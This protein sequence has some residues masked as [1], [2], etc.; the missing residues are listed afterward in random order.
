[1]SLVRHSLGLL[2][3][4]FAPLA[5]AQPEGELIDGIVAVVGSEP[6]LYSELAGRLDQ[7][8]QGGTTITDERTCAELEDL[9]FERLLLEQARLD[10]VVVDEGQVQTE[11][12]RRI[13]Y[14]EA[15]VGGRQ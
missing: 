10:S 9:L 5:H 7:A 3:L 2:A 1:M 13:R 15:Q 8:R 4:L 12:H 6:V 11:L 14:F